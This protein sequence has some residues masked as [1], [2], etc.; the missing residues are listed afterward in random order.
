MISSY[1]KM[2]HADEGFNPDHLLTFNFYPTDTRYEKTRPQLYQQYFDKLRTMPGVKSAAGSMVSAHDR[3][4]RRCH[5][6]ESRGHP[7]S[8]GQKPAAQINVISSQYFRT[9]QIPLL[10]GRDFSGADNLATSQV[11]IVNQAFV[12]KY[13][14]NEDALGRELRPGAGKRIGCRNGVAANRRGSGE[15]RVSFAMERKPEPVMYLP[16]SQLPNWCCMY[17]VVRTSVEPLSL[18]PDMR[19]LGFFNGPRAARDGCEDHAGPDRN[20]SRAATP[21]KPFCWERFA[22][23]ALALDGC[24]AVRCADLF[25]RAEDARHRSATGARRAEKRSPDR[26]F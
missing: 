19:H 7:V 18:E 10:E 17:S 16:S 25:R 21:S 6:R 14:Q 13:L 23:L 20:G 1:A 5:V 3:Q 24:W 2:T 15:T 9:M 12:H 4:C 26:W 22:G 11:M 8:T